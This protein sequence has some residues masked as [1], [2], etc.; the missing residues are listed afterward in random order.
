MK[1]KKILIVEDEQIIAENL[2]LILNEYGYNFVDV[3][4]DVEETEAFFKNTSYDLVLMDI[5]LGET[6]IIDGIDLIKILLQEHSFVYIYVTANADKKTIDKAKKTSPVGYIIKPFI[7]TSIYAN[8][9]MALSTLNKQQV[10]N[11]SYKG[12][13][14]QILISDIAYIAADGAYIKIITLDNKTHFSRKSLL[15]FYDEFPEMFI[16]VHKSNLIN[17][18]HLQSYS[19]QIVKVNNEDI[20]LGRM[21]KQNF[22]DQIKDLSFL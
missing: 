6:S 18:H 5:N 14:Q 19:S 17:K 3:A 7:K 15:D 4:M 20:P 2:R 11:H 16:R 22:L 8:V 21:Y 1:N 13:K 10:F 9:E 12:R